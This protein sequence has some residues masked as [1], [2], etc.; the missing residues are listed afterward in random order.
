[1]MNTLIGYAC[2]SVTQEPNEIRGNHQLVALEQAQR[3]ADSPSPHAETNPR[4]EAGGLFEANKFP[5][6]L[7]RRQFDTQLTQDRHQSRAFGW[8]NDP[9]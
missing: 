9:G 2:I 5:G 6:G 7:Y 1:M 4:C 8:L 3:V